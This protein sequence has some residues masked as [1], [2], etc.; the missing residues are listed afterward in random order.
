MATTWP[1]TLTAWITMSITIPGCPNPSGTTQPAPATSSS[2]VCRLGARWRVR[3]RICFR[4]RHWQPCCLLSAFV[5]LFAAINVK[6]YEGT[7]RRTRSS[8][9]VL[10]KYWVRGFSSKKLGGSGSAT[11]QSQPLDSDNRSERQE[12]GGQ[13]AALLF[14]WP[15][16]AARST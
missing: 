5:G 15:P 2:D 3:R 6:Y 1:A 11:S 4:G 13:G 7:C 9:S 14:V 8:G 10:A 16:S 12:Q